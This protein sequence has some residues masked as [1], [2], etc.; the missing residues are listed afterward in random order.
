ML[1]RTG[2]VQ[3]QPPGREVAKAE[4]AGLPVLLARQVGWDL[5]GKQHRLARLVLEAAAHAREHLAVVLGPHHVGRAVRGERD[6]RRG[7]A[8]EA[9]TRRGVADQPLEQQAQIVVLVIG[10]VIGLARGEQQGVDARPEQPREQ[11]ARA[12]AK[13][14]HHRVQGR[15]QVGEARRAAIQGG[16]QV[17]QHDLPVE[18]TE[19]VAIER[20]DHL[21][22]IAIVAALHQVAQAAGRGAARAAGGR[23]AGARRGRL[24]AW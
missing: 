9:G 14:A 11:A 12:V 20:R 24:P 18:A 13:A 23:T 10:D 2:A 1:R 3:A 21:G 4:A 16:Q 7:D 8:L 15:L 5:A 17:D 19:M 6:K 22:P